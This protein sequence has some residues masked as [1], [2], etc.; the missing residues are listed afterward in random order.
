M[1]NNL[2]IRLKASFLLLVFALNTMVG[3]AC[4]MGLNMGFKSQHEHK[5]A[6]EIH[7]P[8]EKHEHHEAAEKHE[9]KNCCDEQQKGCC[10]DKVTK[11]AL[12]EKTVPQPFH[13]YTTQYSSFPHN[14]LSDVLSTMPGITYSRSFLRSYHPP[15][16]DIRIAISSFLI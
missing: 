9:E 7:I 15:I 11:I 1:K 6:I 5:E 2:S 4:A 12:L 14:Y 16:P 3:F 13:I 8:G 10:N